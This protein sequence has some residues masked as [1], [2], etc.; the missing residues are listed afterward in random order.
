MS[1]PELAWL[2]PFRELHTEARHPTPARPLSEQFGQ[3]SGLKA[4][5]AFLG[6]LVGGSMIPAAVAGAPDPGPLS[7]FFQVYNILLV[8]AHEPLPLQ[9]NSYQQAA[10]KLKLTR[11]TTSQAKLFN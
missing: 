6:H 1:S 7:P 11:K 5:F 10:E 9:S 4:M 3:L 8:P 2:F